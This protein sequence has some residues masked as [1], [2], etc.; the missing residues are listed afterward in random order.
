MKKTFRQQASPFSSNRTTSAS[1]FRPFNSQVSPLLEGLPDVNAA[2]SHCL[3]I[4]LIFLLTF[5]SSAVSQPSLRLDNAIT[6]LHVREI[7]RPSRSHLESVTSPL[8]HHTAEFQDP[9][10]Q[11]NFVILSP[12]NVNAVI[13]KQLSLIVY[14]NTT[15]LVGQLRIIWITNALFC[16]PAHQSGIT[17]PQWLHRFTH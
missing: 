9:S 17:G 8:N 15:V 16:I 4:K 13:L 6:R 2:L 14:N 12:S 3:I 1:V 5:S 11:K 10:S 7:Y